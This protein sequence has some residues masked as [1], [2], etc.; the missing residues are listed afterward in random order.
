MATA[1]ETELSSATSAASRSPERWGRSI[2]TTP[3]SPQAT[4]RASPPL[5]HFRRTA[6]E[7]RTI[8]RGWTLN[9]V[10]ASAT[11]RRVSA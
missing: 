9:K 3:A 1:E 4:P 11:G 8:Q 5:G 10:M 2:R 7:I 6:A